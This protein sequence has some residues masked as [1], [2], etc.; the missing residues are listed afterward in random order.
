[1]IFF[2]IIFGICLLNFIDKY[3]G[4]LL[5]IVFEFIIKFCVLCVIGIFVCFYLFD[6]VLDLVVYV[7]CD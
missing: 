1:M 5:I 2:V 3:F 4:L 7:L 6:G